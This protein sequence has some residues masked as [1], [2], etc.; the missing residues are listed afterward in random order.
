MAD[1][2]VLIIPHANEKVDAKYSHFQNLSVEILLLIFENVGTP[3]SPPLVSLIHSNRHGPTTTDLSQHGS[4]A[5]AASLEDVTQSS[6][7]SDTAKS[8]SR[9]D[10]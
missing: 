5:C 2:S 4:K 8:P 6:H 10:Y 7:P 3:I 1:P 9:I